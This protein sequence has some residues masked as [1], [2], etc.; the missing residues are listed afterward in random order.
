MEKAS[1]WGDLLKGLPAAF[2]ALIIGLIA[3]GIAWRQYQTAKAKLKLDL[4]EKRYAIFE[5]VWGCLSAVV[6]GELEDHPSTAFSNIIPQTG[7]LFGSDIQAYLKDIVAKRIDL[8]MIESK[9]RANSNVVLQEDIGNRLALMQWFADEAT[10][11]CK[12]KF[13]PWLD[14]QNWK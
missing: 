9:A 7:F 14:F 12:A 13:A 3:A 2:V 8:K 10:T 6:Q 5:Q 11:G 1:I 4:F